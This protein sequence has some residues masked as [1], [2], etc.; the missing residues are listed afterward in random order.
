[1]RTSW[2]GIQGAGETAGST[3]AGSSRRA[4]ISEYKNAPDTIDYASSLPKSIKE[5]AMSSNLYHASVGVFSQYLTSLSTLLTKAAANAEA[6]KI[7]PSVFVNARMAP[8]MFALTRQVQIATDHA[9]GAC[10]RLAGVDV[11]SYADTEASFPELQQRITKT[12][13]FIKSLKQA[14]FDGSADK[15]ITLTLGGQKFTWKG[16]VYL[17]N[18]ALP[19]FFFHATTTYN[20]LR[21]NGVDVGKRDFLGSM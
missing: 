9:K 4:G 12:L 7:D 17:Q 6:R 3:R 10:A 14:Q 19:N 20:I 13:E 2:V 15:E 1:M 16:A 18:F 5:R 11:P 8:D 21:L